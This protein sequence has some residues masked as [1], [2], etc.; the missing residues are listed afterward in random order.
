MV[1]SVIYY[2]FIRFHIIYIYISIYIDIY[3]IIT[4]ICVYLALQ[5]GNINV[6]SEIYFEYIFWYKNTKYSYLKPCLKTVSYHGTNEYRSILIC[7]NINI[8]KIIILNSIPFIN[9]CHDVN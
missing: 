7:N 3:H 5:N 2:V 9:T 6:L 1:Y 8:L 4:C